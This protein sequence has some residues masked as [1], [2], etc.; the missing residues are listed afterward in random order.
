VRLTHDEYVAAITREGDALAR[1]ARD[2]GVDAPVRS[3]PDWTVG[4]LLGHV[5][6]IHRWVTTIIV[7]APDAPSAH[8]SQNEPPPIDERIDWFVGGYGELARVLDEKDPDTTVWT[9][10]PDGTAGF[11]A[12][13]MAHEIAVHRW[14]AQTAVGE[15][16]PI[17]RALAVD[18]IQEA[19]DMVPVRLAHNLPRGEGE[20][21]HLHCIDGEGEW[22]IRLTPDGPV[23]TN[24]HAKGDV[25]AR[26]TASDLVLLVWGRIAPDQ[27]EVFGDASLLARWQEL[28]R[29]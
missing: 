10:T 26:G 28:A 6:R 7:S 2:A 11:W 27:V 12:R 14:D 17:D 29:F 3:C 18:G 9:W 13:R 20:T 8:W 21:I 1:A 23:F 22:L 4:D 25:A 19:F 16:Q 5:G 15:P 24:E